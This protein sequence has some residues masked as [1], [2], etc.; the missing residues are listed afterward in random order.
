M[1][2]NAVL[3]IIIQARDEATASLKKIGEEMKAQKKGFEDQAR[4]L[5]GMGT[6]FTAIGAPITA[7]VGLSVK[8]YVETG[9]ALLKMAAQTG[10][11]VEGLSKLKFAAESNN[12]SLESV[13]TAL[14][15]MQRAVSGAAA[16]SKELQGAFQAIGVDVEALRRLSPEGQFEALAEAVSRVKDP[17]DRAAAAVGVFGRGGL[18]LLPVIREGAAG[19]RRYGEDA[20]RIGAVMSGEA[21][22]GAAELGAGMQ[23]LKAS[24]G[25]LSASVGQA[26]GP[27]LTKL[28]DWVSG[29]IQGF[30]RWRE[31]NKTLADWVV[32]VAAALGAVMAVVGPLLLVLPTLIA[33]VKAVGAAMSL[34]AL[35]PIGAALVALGVTI[36]LLIKYWDQVVEAFQ[37]GANFLMGLAEDIVN[38]Y[39]APINLIISG[40]NQVGKVLGFH[41]DEVKLK[42]PEWKRQVRAVADEHK[43]LGATVEETFDGVIGQYQ[44]MGDAVRE[45]LSALTKSFEDGTMALKEFQESGELGWNQSIEQLEEVAVKHES[46]YERVAKAAEEARAREV[47][48][49]DKAFAALKQ[50]VESAR[51]PVSAVSDPLQRLAE[52]LS[53]GGATD[54]FGN[55]LVPGHPLYDYIASLF[56]NQP[57]PSF[58]GGPPVPTVA[59]T[60]FAGSLPGPAGRGGGFGVAG[61]GPSTGSG[62]TGGGATTVN[63]YGDVHRDDAERVAAA[64]SAARRRGMSA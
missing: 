42:L 36:V 52:E 21:A 27:A 29:A 56:A 2:A 26:V 16:G 25:A 31:E 1:A 32:K 51:S 23:E 9:E 37:K 61:G 20:E 15:Q 46:V 41:I 64:F 48:A 57:L 13:G 11:A 3:Q 10:I 54:A 45:N 8:G 19:L 17:A 14:G 7:F 24:M 6:A 35:N 18:E 49:A 44:R 12:V 43:E 22:E 59:A 38:A 58:P 34:L 28:V 62:R 40:L 39:L 60:S 50:M 4:A 53:K 47:E 5:R 30:N 55:P 63:F 33:S